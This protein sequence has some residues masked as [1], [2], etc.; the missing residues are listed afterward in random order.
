MYNRETNMY[1]FAKHHRVYIRGIT[2]SIRGMEK[3]RDRSVSI[4]TGYGLDNRKMGI[5]FPA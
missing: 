1:F 3:S 5:R 4:A 2:G